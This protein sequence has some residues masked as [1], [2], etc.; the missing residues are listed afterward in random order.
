MEDKTVIGSA[1]VTPEPQT[2]PPPP[3]PPNY[4][5]FY[6]TP[7]PEPPKKKSNTGLIIGVVVVLL[8]CCCCLI[9]IG[10]AWTFGDTIMNMMQDVSLLPHFAAK[11][12]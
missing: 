10:L 2:P 4:E 6:A 1:P 3:P 7:T 9:T 11:L 12:I 5:P 8:L